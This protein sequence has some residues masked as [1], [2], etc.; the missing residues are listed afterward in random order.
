[1]IQVPGEHLLLQID[2]IF[3][4]EECKMLIQHANSVGYQDVD[5][6]NAVYSRVVGRVSIRGMPLHD[7]LW[8]RL[9][10]FIPTDVDGKRVVGLNDHF[11]FSKYHAGQFFDVHKDG[12]NQDSSGN[13]S[14]LTLRDSIQ[15][16]RITRFL[17]TKIH[18]N[19][20]C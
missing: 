11:R 13:R 15:A 18:L 17:H 2:D 5:R 16:I 8:A 1:M 4:V 19:Q 12:I 7:F 10:P 3:T 20:T 14:A 9:Q 6:G